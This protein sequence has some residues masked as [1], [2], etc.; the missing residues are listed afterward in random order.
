MFQ[1]LAEIVRECQAGDSEG[2]SVQVGLLPIGLLGLLAD[3]LDH[4]V[5]LHGIVWAVGSI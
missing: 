4:L 3:G 5:L 2:V 1:H